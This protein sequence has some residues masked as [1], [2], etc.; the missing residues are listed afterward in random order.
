[1]PTT[2]DQNTDDQ[3][4]KPW[5]NIW[6]KTNYTNL[7][8]KNRCV[9]RLMH[10]ANEGKHPE[11]LN[12]CVLLSEDV[13]G[14]EVTTMVEPNIIEDQINLCHK[15]LADIV[16]QHF[17]A[18]DGEE[19]C[20]DYTIQSLRSV[21]ITVTQTLL[22]LKIHLGIDSFKI[23]IFNSLALSLLEDHRG[24]LPTLLEQIKTTNFSES[25]GS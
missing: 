19:L 13:D 16:R 3:E 22:K 11:V 18:F 4:E 14:K 10:Q 7:Y 1:M 24:E 21:L 9:A 25:E 5:R 2:N 6:V 12:G 17:D 15:I 23:V 20:K 8:C